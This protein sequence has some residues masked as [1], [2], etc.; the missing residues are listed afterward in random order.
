MP[1]ADIDEVDW[2]QT[3]NL[4]LTVQE[5]RNLFKPKPSDQTIYRLIWAGKLKVL[6]G[7]GITRIPLSEL[8]KFF[9]K[10][11]VYKPRRKRT[12]TVAKRA[13]R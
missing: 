4:A 5:A 1:Q 9:G 2:G 10:V 8:R 11:K 13:S 6:D 12:G 7:P 3:D